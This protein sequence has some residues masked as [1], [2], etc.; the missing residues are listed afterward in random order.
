MK[1]KKE[2]KRTGSIGMGQHPAGRP[3]SRGWIKEQCK[4]SYLTSNIYSTEGLVRLFIL[5]Y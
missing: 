2:Q 4:V 3:R 1:G 5:F